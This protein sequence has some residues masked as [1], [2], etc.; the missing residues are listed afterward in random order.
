MADTVA[1]RSAFGCIGLNAVTHNAMVDQGITSMLDLCMFDKD[2]VT[3]LCKAVRKANPAPV[4][5]AAAAEILNNLH[6]HQ[7]KL[8]TMVYWTKE[9]FC[10][11]LSKVYGG[12]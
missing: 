3:N 9:Q 8:K 2:G 4:D 5:G 12:H 6:I 11:G 10:L 1:I 7:L